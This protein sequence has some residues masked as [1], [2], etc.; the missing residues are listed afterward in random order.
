MATSHAV[1][2]NGLTTGITGMLLENNRTLAGIADLSGEGLSPI[3]DLTTAVVFGIALDPAIVA[4]LSRGPSAAYGDEY[5][6][7][8]GRLADLGTRVAGMLQAAGYR[9]VA[10]A[11][12]TGKFDRETLSAEFPH[13]TAATRAGLGWV[14]KC[15]LLVTRDYGSAIR[16]ASVLTNAPLVPG[17][18]VTRSFCG[19][20]TECLVA[21]PA[22]APSGR[23]WTPGLARD[24][25]WD[26]R[27]CH[28]QCQ[29]NADDLGLVHPVCG[30]CIAACPWTERYIQRTNG[31]SSGET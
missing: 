14:G 5:A 24:S 8:N 13:K 2:M 3:A 30:I 27:A 4:T 12:S 29:K 1:S 31:S 28:A 6:R 23:E 17:R 16:F 21:C 11:P 26:S 9:A 10:I 25:F 7:A 22:E 20:C 18:P 15:A 19:K